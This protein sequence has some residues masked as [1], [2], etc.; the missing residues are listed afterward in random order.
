MERDKKEDERWRDRVNDDLTGIKAFVE[1]AGEE[2]EA[3]AIDVKETRHTIR[4]NCQFQLNSVAR[5][6]DVQEESIRMM[7]KEMQ[8]I[9]ERMPEKLGMM[10][11]SGNRLET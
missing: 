5:S 8:G 1:M 4:I 2:R 9:S 3:D 7:G 6:L 10:S 11:H